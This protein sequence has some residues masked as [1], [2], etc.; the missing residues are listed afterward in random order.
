MDYIKTKDEFSMFKYDGIQ[1]MRIGRLDYAMECFERALAIQDDIETRQFYARALISTNDLEGAIEELENIRTAEPDNTDNL[2]LLADLYFQTED[3]EKTEEVCNAA[4][5]LDASLAAPHCI[6]GQRYFS[7]QDF[8]NAVAQ[9]TLA[10][11]AHEDYYD[12]YFLRAKVLHTMAQF[13]EASKDID[14]VL[15]HAEDNDEVTLLKAMISEGQEKNKEAEEYYRKTIELNPFA[16]DAYLHLGAL[17]MKLGRKKEAEE[18]AK[19]AMEY[20]PDAMEGINGE[21][22]NWEEVVKGNNP[23]S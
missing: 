18:L 9:S 6:L 3:Y 2:I 13:E 11:T 20:A 10:I 5:E 7:T 14:V 1:A 4:L 15:A 12:A 21:Y 16:S 23:F 22:T 19:E 8:I 17:M